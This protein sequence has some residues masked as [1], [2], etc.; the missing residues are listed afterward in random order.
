M[1]SDNVTAVVQQ[2]L[3]NEVDP[4]HYKFVFRPQTL[5]P[6]VDVQTDNTNTQD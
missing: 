3:P 4:N 1:R 6:E 5:I 2:T